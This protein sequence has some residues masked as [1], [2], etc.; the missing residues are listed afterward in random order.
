MGISEIS[1]NIELCTTIVIYMLVAPLDWK[2]KTQEKYQFKWEG[3]LARLTDNA[4]TSVCCME[5]TTLTVPSTTPGQ[6][7]VPVNTLG[8][9]DPS[10]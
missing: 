3:W 6:H 7:G 4:L 5:V 9:E 1:R 8:S 2:K 10:L